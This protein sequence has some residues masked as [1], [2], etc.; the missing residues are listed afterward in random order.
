M[1][2]CSGLTARLQLARP[3]FMGHE[4]TMEPLRSLSIIKSSLSFQSLMG[5]RHTLL[6]GVHRS[7]G[8]SLKIRRMIRPRV[9][10]AMR[11]HILDPH[12][13]KMKRMRHDNRR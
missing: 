12:G 5:G 8:A 13:L 11:L 2:T 6:T 9:R 10:I 4:N 7:W 3:F 1:S